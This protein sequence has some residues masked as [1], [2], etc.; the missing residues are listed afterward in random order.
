MPARDGE[1]V[2][3]LKK[4]GTVTLNASGQGVLN[5]STD[6]SNQ[7]WEVTAVMVSTNQP[8][9]A[10]TVPVA[11]LALNTPVIGTAS[12]GN[13]RGSSWSGNS[14]TFAQGILPV[15]PM[16]TL[17]VLWAPPN[18]VSGAPLS[19]VLATA[20]VTGTKYTRRQAGRRTA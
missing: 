2:G 5:F 16:D 4:S 9:T 7:R 14:D 17:N 12:P 6:N 11:T 15:G 13:Q 1:L 3:D 8:G 18:G 20:V 19:G 10:T